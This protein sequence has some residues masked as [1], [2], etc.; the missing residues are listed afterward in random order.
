MLAVS[1]SFHFTHLTK[2]LP[3]MSSAQ[4]RLE[5]HRLIHWYLKSLQQRWKMERS[6]VPKNCLRPIE[7]HSLICSTPYISRHSLNE[8]FL[9]N[10]NS[11]ISVGILPVNIIW[12]TN[13][14][15]E[16]NK[17]TN[18]WACKNKV[19]AKQS[20]TLILAYSYSPKI[21]SSRIVNNP[22]SLGMEPAI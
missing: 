2:F 19:Q 1:H 21:S 18:L 10:V 22:I 12:S 14:E 20:G 15:E 13:Q 11:P 7:Q 3:G 16:L 8:N 17:A 4:S 6:W 5:S 9:N